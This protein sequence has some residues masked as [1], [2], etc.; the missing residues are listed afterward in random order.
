MRTVSSDVMSELCGNLSLAPYIVVELDRDWSSTVLASDAAQSCMYGVVAAKA[1]LEEIRQ[2]ANFATAT[3]YHFRM[4]WSDNDEPERLREGPQWRLSLSAVDFPVFF[5][6]KARRKER[7]VAMDQAQNHDITAN[8]CFCVS[9]RK[10]LCMRSTE[11]ALRR[12][13]YAVLHAISGPWLREGTC[14]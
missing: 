9:I 3:S 2:A 12:M 8:G 7:V 14:L 5:A 6:A 1:D 4:S 11:A 13:L 10:R